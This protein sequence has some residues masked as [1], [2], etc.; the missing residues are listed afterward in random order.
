MR[1]WWLVGFVVAGAAVAGCS[2]Q[3]PPAATQ[4]TSAPAIS[5]D[6]EARSVTIDAVVA[7]QETYAELRGAIE[8][9]L[10]S[11]GGKEYESLFVTDVR[12]QELQDALLQI[13]LTPG[14]PA[15]PAQ[16]QP[17]R[18][19]PVMI[20]VEWKSDGASKQAPIDGFVL[21]VS[22]NEQ[23]DVSIDAAA[24]KTKPATAASGA[25]RALSAVAWPFT[26][27]FQGADPQ[28]GHPILQ[29]D[30]TQSL[31]C[32]HPTD[33]SGLFQNPRPESRQNNIYHA[34]AAAL[35]PAGTPVRVVFERPPA[36]ATS[37]FH[38]LIS[39]R[40]QGVGFRAFVD[41][42]AKRI[43]G[44]TGFVRNL[45]DGRVEVLVEGASVRV[46]DFVDAIRQGPRSARV[47]KFEAS[48]QTPE[49]DLRAFE[50]W[51]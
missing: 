9:V 30:L 42:Q 21:R 17:P 45:P 35:P 14:S 23:P 37:R 47:E 13:G 24:A 32:L 4:P 51:Q 29:A 48:E 3:T 41:G 26:G 16:D 10:V 33:N 38:I 11:R 49:G 44:L 31:I 34:N 18:G 8:Y 6:R 40:V 25:A 39:G 2:R 1:T 22:G 20:R 5:I 28:S 50:I 19:L 36:R 7:P 46:R 12:P 27:S 43:G 15:D